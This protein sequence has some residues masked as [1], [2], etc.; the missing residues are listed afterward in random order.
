MSESI[1]NPKW[2]EMLDELEKLCTLHDETMASSNK[3][4]EFNSKAS[5][6]LSRLED[7]GYDRLADLFM[8]LLSS[9]SP[10]EISHCDNH[11]RTKGTLERIKLRAK[12]IAKI[13]MH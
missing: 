4:R 8:D 9:C 12:E 7:M 5:L 10:K 3:C 13:G 1:D 2:N 11:D 6:F